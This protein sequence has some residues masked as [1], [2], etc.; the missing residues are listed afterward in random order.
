LLVK[1]RCPNCDE[2]LKIARSHLGGRG[3]CP[4]CQCIVTLREE[5]QAIGFDSTGDTRVYSR[6]RSR[7]VVSSW[8]GALFLVL[9]TFVLLLKFMPGEDL[10]AASRHYVKKLND[11]LASGNIQ[12]VSALLGDGDESPLLSTLAHY[13][14]ISV[15][16]EEANAGGERGSRSY[17]CVGKDEKTGREVQLIFTFKVV[18]GKPVKVLSIQPVA[19]NAPSSQA[20]SAPQSD[21]K[22]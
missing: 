18:D 17:I 8:L 11:A 3:L 16:K 4:G 9:F 20:A 7:F 12:A 2:I 6:R 19:A 10:L 21:V 1:V 5:G 13:K 14:N 22:R 15:L